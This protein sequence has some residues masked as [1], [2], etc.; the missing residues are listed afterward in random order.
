MLYS[1]T[2]II[3]S[4]LKHGS[5]AFSPALAQHTYPFSLSVLMTFAFLMTGPS[6]WWWLT[7][8]ENSFPTSCVGY[9]SQSTKCAGSDGSVTMRRIL[10]CLLVV[11]GG[12]GFC[13]HSHT[14]AACQTGTEDRHGAGSEALW[15]LVAGGRLAA[16]SSPGQ[17]WPSNF[18]AFL[19]FLISLPPTISFPV[20]QTIPCISGQACWVWDILDKWSQFLADLPTSLLFMSGHAIVWCLTWRVQW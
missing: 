6:W 15:W 12:L 2:L 19:L 16:G 18:Q 11:V 1:L 20:W 4:Q 7:V 13:R 9:S 3:S 8:A 17:W 5:M 14:S 10:L